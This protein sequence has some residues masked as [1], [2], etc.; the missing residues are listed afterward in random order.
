MRWKLTACDNTVMGY[1]MTLQRVAQ[2][3]LMHWA[4]TPSI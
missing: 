3:F 2:G 4:L 1:C